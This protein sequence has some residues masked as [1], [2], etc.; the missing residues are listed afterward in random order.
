MSRD[1]TVCLIRSASPT[2]KNNP[3]GDPLAHC[4]VG[5]AIPQKTVV[6]VPFWIAWYKKR[7]RL[8]QITG[9]CIDVRPN[10]GEWTAGL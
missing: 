9:W 10:Q 3:S 4:Q 2:V 7:S 5:P 8:E 1:G 6:W